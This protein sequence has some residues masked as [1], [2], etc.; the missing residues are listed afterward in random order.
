MSSTPINR[1][2]VRKWALQMLFL[3]DV[4]HVDNYKQRIKDDSLLNMLYSVELDP[5][6]ENEIAL[7]DLPEIG[8][9]NKQYLY[10]VIEKV[11]KHKAAID[12]M[13]DE[14]S[15]DWD[16]KRLQKV[17]VNI[18]RIAVAEMFYIKDVPG[19]VA[20]NEAV[21]L[22]KIFSEDKSASFING[23]LNSIWQKSGKSQMI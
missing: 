5:E 2:Q 9:P 21:E 11:S 14:N 4:T 19:V 6:L 7:D 16:V 8:E 1:R 18:M 22:A 13:I 23:V 15:N 20:I 10:D 12:I 17:D 3:F